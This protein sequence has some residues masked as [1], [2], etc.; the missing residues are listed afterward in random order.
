MTEGQSA[1]TL[2]AAVVGIINSSLR[3][4]QS[5]ILESS[6]LFRDLNA[7]SI[8][9]LDIKYELE[10]SFAVEISDTEIRDSLGMNLTQAEVY[11]KLTVRSIIDFI[12]RKTGA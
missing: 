1:E 9:L 7:E 3:I 10:R 12:E 11:E 4:P 5:R 6:R 8:D 2:K